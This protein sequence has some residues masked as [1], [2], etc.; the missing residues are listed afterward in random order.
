MTM[1][2]SWGFTLIEL[3]VVLAIIAALASLAWP[4]YVAQLENTDE[5]MLREN[6]RL[7]RHSIDR[8]YE[9]N[10]RYPDTVQELVD[11]RYIRALPIDPL[12]RSTETWLIIPPPAGEKGQLGDIRSGARG[13]SRWGIAYVDL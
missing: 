4:R 13:T 6:L 11:R 2:R 5:V 10:T 1:R 8:F 3:I 9:D 7:V 12:T